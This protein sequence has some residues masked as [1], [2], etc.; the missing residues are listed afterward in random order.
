MGDGADDAADRAFDY[1]FEDD[2]EAFGDCDP[3]FFPRREARAEG[4]GS[5]PLCGAET[6][7]RNGKF[8]P[9]YGCSKFPKCKGSRDATSVKW[10]SKKRKW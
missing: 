1:I 6:V 2:G 8:G 5:C 9:F 10:P 4:S 3:P 7:P